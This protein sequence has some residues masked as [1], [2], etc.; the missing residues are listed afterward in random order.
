MMVRDPMKWLVD[1]KIGNDYRITGHD[2]NNSSFQINDLGSACNT[3][4][5]LM[6][7]GTSDAYAVLR[8]QVYPADQNFTAIR[9][10]SMVSNDVV[11][12]TIPG[13]S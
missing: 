5:W 3:Q 12:V 6:G 11:N 2:F 1:Y 7:D 9:M 8:N 4:V 10:L 13:L